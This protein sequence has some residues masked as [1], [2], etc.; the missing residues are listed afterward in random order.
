MQVADKPDSQNFV[1]G[2]YSSIIKTPD[3]PGPVLDKSG[4]ILG[5]HHGLQHYTIGQR[6]GLQIAAGEPLYVTA[7]DPSRNA[8]ILGERSELQKEEFTAS[9]INWIAIPELAQPAI[10]KTRIR[11]A[12]KETEAFVTPELNGPD[13]STVRVKFKQPQIAIAPGQV[14]VFYQEDV[15]IG[16]GI[17]D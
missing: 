1:C 3:V 4:K 2:E 13:R 10:F 16:G 17:I 5:Q 14:V 6:K 7:I 8:V 12:Q 11:S 9:R 15:V